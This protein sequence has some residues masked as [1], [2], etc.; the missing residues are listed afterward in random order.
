MDVLY[1][2]K[3]DSPELVWSLR[4]LAKNG[5]NLGRVVVAMQEGEKPAWMSD[6]VEFVKTPRNPRVKK[7]AFK[8]VDI[9]DCLV[10]AM[11]E[12]GLGHALFSSDDHFLLRES[13]L[14]QWPW[15]VHGDYADRKGEDHAW[16]QSLA[17]TREV[18][19]RHGM[20]FG[21]VSGHYNSHLLA[22]ALPDVKSLM[23]PDYLDGMFGFEP[24]GV[25]AS[26]ALARSWTP[27]L[28]DCHDVKWTSDPEFG[29]VSEVVEKASENTGQVSVSRLGDC[30]KLFKAFREELFPDKC[31]ME[32]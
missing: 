12:T 29:D 30:P 25:F 32:R 24:A 18:L 6:R 19:E 2:L 8:H 15:Y 16:Y 1:I 3:K 20:Y 26:C 10:R 28:V 7:G 22:E 5:R 31:V 4:S 17:Y 21:A 13:D 14:D 27:A 9:L 23:G 11:E